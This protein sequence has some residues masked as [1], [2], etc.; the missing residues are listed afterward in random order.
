[1]AS[2]FK[3]ECGTDMPHSLSIIQFLKLVEIPQRILIRASA[4]HLEV[5]V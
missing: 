3:Y 4:N 5:E 1:M 2:R